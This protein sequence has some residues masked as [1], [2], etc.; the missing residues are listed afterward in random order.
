M[1]NPPAK[2]GFAGGL[3]F[4]YCVVLFIWH[5][6]E[7]RLSVFELKLIIQANR[8]ELRHS[9]LEETENQLRQHFPS[10]IVDVSRWAYSSHPVEDEFLVSVNYNARNPHELRT[11]VTNVL[12]LKAESL[13][14][15]V[16]GQKY[17]LNRRQ[18]RKKQTRAGRT[19]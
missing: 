16:T 17:P 6:K 18:R 2:L 12:R 19:T 13:T 9:I 11:F 5:S 15:L 4:V 7:R 1:H 10:T 8:M 3:F 14:N